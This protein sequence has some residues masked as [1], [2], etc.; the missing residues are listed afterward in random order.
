MKK[1]K[2]QKK[3]YREISVD[4]LNDSY[5]VYVFIGDKSKSISAIRKYLEDDIPV[6]DKFNTGLCFFRMGYQPCIWIEDEKNYEILAHESVHAL[7]HIC[8]Y[9]K[10]DI[11]EESG[12]EFMAHSVEAILR[13][14]IRNK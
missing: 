5:K 14:C 4:L 9:I 10:M 3:R 6:I 7:M 2:K 11:R 1:A 12:N 8:N 13:K